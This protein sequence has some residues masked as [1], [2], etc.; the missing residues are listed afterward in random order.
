MTQV[1][2]VV[3]LSSRSRPDSTIS[4]MLLLYFNL[5]PLTRSKAAVFPQVVLSCSARRIKW[6]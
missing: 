6:G 4:F 2:S 5:L 3:I 1:E